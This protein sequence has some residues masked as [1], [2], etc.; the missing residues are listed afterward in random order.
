VKRPVEIPWRRHLRA[1][2]ILAPIA[3][4]G[5]ALCGAL[6]LHLPHVETIA[7]WL[8][9]ASAFLVALGC[10][11]AWRRPTPFALAAVVLTL[12]E[13]FAAGRSM[14][15]NR[16]TAPESLEALR[17][18]I[19][20]LQTQ[21]SSRVLGLSDATWDPGDLADITPAL[22]GLAPV[23]ITSYVDAVK[24]KELLTAN[25]RR[26]TACRASMAT[27]AACFP[28]TLCRHGRTASPGRSAFP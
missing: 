12:G 24:N 21:A 9:I 25:L 18:A 15:Y 2:G 5:F 14:E 6:F 26:F 20:F 27:M 23:Q 19:A 16:S 8:F 1:L 10:G 7:G 17:P 22:A 28:S 4:S 3:A 11:A 13:L